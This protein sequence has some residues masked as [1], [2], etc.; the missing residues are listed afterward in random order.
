MKCL[1]LILLALAL[2]VNAAAPWSIAHWSDCHAGAWCL[3]TNA[4]NLFAYVLSK[5]NDGTL[6]IKG[7]VLTGDVYEQD[8]NYFNGGSYYNSNQWQFTAATNKFRSFVTNGVFLI[9]CNGNHD[10]DDFANTYGSWTDPADVSLAWSNMFSV[11]FF[12]GQTNYVPGLNWGGSAIAND[13]RQMV[14]T[15]TNSGVNLAF[16]TFSSSFSNGIPA[17]GI[18]ADIF[19]QIAPQTLW[20]S[21][22]LASLPNY[23]GIALAHFWL[24]HDLKAGQLGNMYHTVRNYP[25]LTTNDWNYAYYQNIGPGIVPF[26]QGLGS[27]SNLFMCLGGHT[28][29]L[30]KGHLYQ[31]RAGGA[32]DIQSFNM[33]QTAGVLGLPNGQAVSV[34][35]FYPDL[36]KAVTRTFNTLTGAEITNNAVDVGTISSDGA[37]NYYQHTW[38]TPLAVPRQIR[39]MG[40]R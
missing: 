24:G 22:Q 12:S 36:K 21:N 6:N 26:F 40:T 5:T 31:P 16:A 9:A 2:R 7:L 25:L 17:S 20:V 33:Q 3:S 10:A 19:S 34:I 11:D 38:T 8:T 15:Y 32:V 30:R 18:F 35:T 27:C 23:N 39:I 1:L 37:S 4:D 14:M 28:Q 13:A 29:S